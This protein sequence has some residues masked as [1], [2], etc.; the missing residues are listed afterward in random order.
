MSEVEN[1]V[2]DDK[3]NIHDAKKS[4]KFADNKKNIKQMIS[5]VRVNFNGQLGKLQKDGPSLLITVILAII[6]MAQIGRASCRERV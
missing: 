5:R 1:S 4:D 6:F 2:S 3:K